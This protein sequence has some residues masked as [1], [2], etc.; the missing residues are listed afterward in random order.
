VRLVVVETI[1]VIVP[2]VMLLLLKVLTLLMS[3]LNPTMRISDVDDVVQISV[4]P[5]S[6]SAVFHRWSETARRV[7]VRALPVVLLMNPCFAITVECRVDFGCCVKHRLE[8]LHK[9]I[10]FFVVLR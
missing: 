2:L 9:C 5:P 10:N 7:P 4:I 3:V 6:P 8:V 1:V